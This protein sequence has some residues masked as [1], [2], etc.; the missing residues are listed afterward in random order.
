M[1]NKTKKGIERAKELVAQLDLE[2]LKKIATDFIQRSQKEEIAFDILPSMSRAVYSD[3]TRG[4]FIKK[5]GITEDIFSDMIEVISNILHTVL[6]ETE[7]EF[8][9]ELGDELLAIKFKDLFSFVKG[10]A[11]F[12]EIKNHYLVTKYCKSRYL[13]EIDWEINLKNSQKPDIDEKQPPMFPSC[14]VRLFL[15]S[16]RSPLKRIAEREPE[17][18]TF[19]LSLSD[20]VK[21]SET[22]ITIKERM[23]KVTQRESIG[24]G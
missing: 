6:D 15:Q 1:S 20:A 3:K 17:I 5:Y 4:T 14:V 19:E 12:S 9:Q 7:V 11:Q 16:P 10:M 18:V 8:L 23:T 21:L 24:C 2:L 13:D 22:F